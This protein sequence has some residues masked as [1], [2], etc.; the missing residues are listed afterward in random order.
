MGESVRK[1]V[2]NGV[3][4]LQRGRSNALPI[5][6]WPLGAGIPARLVTSRTGSA[7]LFRAVGQGQMD[8]VLV[9]ADGRVSIRVRLALDLADAA[10]QRFGD[11]SIAIDWSRATIARGP[12]RSLLTRTELRLL[13]VLVDHSGSV[14]S[15]A[16]LIAAVWPNQGLA[17]EDRENALAVYVCTLRKRLAA[18]GLG[19]ALHTVRRA[20]YEITL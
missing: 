7:R 12:K 10:E 20:G 16:A 11:G 14:V 9:S 13:S 4:D 3:I 15:R 19:N 6:A 5:E 8:Y 17:W 2:A 1:R 18:I